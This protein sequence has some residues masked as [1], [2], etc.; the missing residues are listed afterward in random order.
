MKF[1]MKDPKELT[2]ESFSNY[3]SIDLEL[4]KDM[5]ENNESLY[6]PTRL[7][8]KKNK[9]REIDPPTRK[10]KRQGRVMHNFFSAN[11]PIHKNAHGGIKKRSAFTSAY[12]HQMRKIILTFDIKDCYPSINRQSLLTQL[13]IYGFTVEVATAFS[14][15]MT[16][17]DRIPQG[18]PLSGDAL[19]F[20]LYQFDCVLSDFCSK[21]SAKYTRFCDDI[22]ISINNKCNITAIEQK[23]FAELSHLG[24]SVNQEK[25]NANGVQYL[26]E[27]PTVHSLVLLP[28][29]GLT[30]NDAQRKAAQTLALSYYRNCTSLSCNTI[31]IA[32]VKRRKLIGYINHMSQADQ[33]HIKEIRSLLRRGDR[34][35]AAILQNHEIEALNGKWWNINNCYNEPKR[36][37]HLS[38]GNSRR[39]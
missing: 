36:I 26:K 29:G 14:F 3:I 21:N 10:F 4:I 38:P 6:K 15:L 27:K 13:M 23:V 17:K 19:N 24:L 31:E 30:I 22:V 9:I 2:L 28:Q 12:N 16:R 20:H 25:R 5:V 11:L 33:S 37:A 1:Q 7:Q 35:V 34:K 18:S 39:M 8:R 32:A